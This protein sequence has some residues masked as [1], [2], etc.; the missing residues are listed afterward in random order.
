MLYAV[1]LNRFNRFT[2]TPVDIHH[3]VCKRVKG[4]AIKV[5]VVGTPNPKDSRTRSKT[6]KGGGASGS[7]SA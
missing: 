3:S 5:I 2:T 6:C 1:P 7:S 4:V